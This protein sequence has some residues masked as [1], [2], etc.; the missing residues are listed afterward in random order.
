M[1]WH[2]RRSGLR[3]FWFFSFDGRLGIKISQTAG[4]TASD[5][6]VPKQHAQ[7]LRKPLNWHDGQ[8]DGMGR[9]R[10]GK[11]DHQGWTRPDNSALVAPVFPANTVGP[12]PW[13]SN[14]P[15]AAH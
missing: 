8:M 5:E 10:D 14:K 12:T 13:R 1:A 2:A 9:M 4:L 3:V 11:G 6:A 7:P 15:S